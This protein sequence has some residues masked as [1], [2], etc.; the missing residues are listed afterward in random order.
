ME[1]FRGRWVRISEKSRIWRKGFASVCFLLAAFLGFYLRV[2]VFSGFSPGFFQGDSI[3]PS[4]HLLS[5]LSYGSDLGEC[6]DGHWNRD[7]PD[8]MMRASKHC[9]CKATNE[10]G[11]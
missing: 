3:S 2:P 8:Q 1:G 9:P 5:L 10:T 11:A 4:L 7:V 6:E